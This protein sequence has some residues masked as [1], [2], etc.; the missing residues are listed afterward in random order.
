MLF[1][2]DL[3]NYIKNKRGWRIKD[4]EKNIN[5]IIFSINFQHICLENLFNFILISNRYV[6]HT[7]FLQT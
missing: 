1:K 7:M 4:F 2:E 3:K 5:K 6:F